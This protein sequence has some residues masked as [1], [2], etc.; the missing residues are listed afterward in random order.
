MKIR[1]GKRHLGEVQEKLGTSFQVSPFNGVT[2]GQNFP[3]N[4]VENKEFPTREV[5]QKPGV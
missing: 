2:Q 1:R 5:H 3:H 4:N